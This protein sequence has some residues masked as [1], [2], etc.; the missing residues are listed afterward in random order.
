MEW[1]HA[2]GSWTRCLYR[3]SEIGFMYWSLKTAGWKSR[4][5]GRTGVG[6]FNSL[7]TTPSTICRWFDSILST[8]KKENR[9]LRTIAVKFF[10]ILVDYNIYRHSRAGLVNFR[11]TLREWRKSHVKGALCQRTTRAGSRYRGSTPRGLSIIN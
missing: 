3:E 1:H 10:E 2:A 7:R 5:T 6:T 4:H 11:A 9:L 8:K